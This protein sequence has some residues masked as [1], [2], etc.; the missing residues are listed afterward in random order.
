M[1]V[2]IGRA[3]ASDGAHNDLVAAAA[4]VATATRSDAGCE[5]YT[6]ALDVTD[7]SCLVSI[8][9]WSSQ[10]ALD[11]HLQHEHTRVFLDAVGGLVEGEP[12][13][14][15]LTATPA[16]GSAGDVA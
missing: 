1:L 16:A 2:V 13:M 9:V 8:E 15:F 11:A 3:R 12:S 4:R 7:P 5:A 14:T 10:A 6:F